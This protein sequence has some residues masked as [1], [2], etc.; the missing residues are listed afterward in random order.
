MKVYVSGGISGVDNYEEIFA[1]A[2]KK[3]REVWKHEVISPA[4]RDEEIGKDKPWGIYLAEDLAIILTDPDLE[5]IVMLPGW[6]RSKGACLEKHAAE[7]RG[8]RIIFYAEPKDRGPITRA[9][10]LVHGD[11]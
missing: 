3:I 10:P 2:T 7:A 9:V 6:E 5:G 4:E 11:R 8:L 1:Q